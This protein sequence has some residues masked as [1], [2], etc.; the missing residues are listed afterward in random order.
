MSELQTVDSLVPGDVVTFEL[1]EDKNT[2]EFEYTGE[3]MYF[4]V[5][6]YNLPDH[7]RWGWR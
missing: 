1:G 3:E 4:W 6:S 2:Y 7:P 5:D